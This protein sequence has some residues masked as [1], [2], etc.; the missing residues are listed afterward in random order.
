MSKLSEKVTQDLLNRLQTQFNVTP[1]EASDKQI[2]LALSS[3]ICEL[4]KTKR[5]KFMNHVNSTGE[6]QIFYL[7]MEFLMGRSLKTSLY[8]L[9]LADDIAKFLKQFDIK[10]DRIYDYEPDAG[11]GNGGLGRLA[12][13]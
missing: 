13:C 7:S 5:Q 2:Y 12:A 6:K 9:E 8:N 1:D 10:L 11:L 3:V 4:M